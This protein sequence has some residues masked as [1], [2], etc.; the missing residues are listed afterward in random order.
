M[1]NKPDE[2]GKIWRT[3]SMIFFIWDKR[4]EHNLESI[5]FKTK[6][7]IAPKTKSKT[8]FLVIYQNTFKTW[9]TFYLKDPFIYSIFAT[10]ENAPFGRKCIILKMN[11]VDPM[12]N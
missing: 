6:S 2:S 11:C 10:C 3:Y 9:L 7:K 8:V 1:Y 12:G 5:G 4:W